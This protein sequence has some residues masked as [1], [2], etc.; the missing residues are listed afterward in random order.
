MKGKQRGGVGGG[1][2]K[3]IGCSGRKVRAKIKTFHINIINNP[4]IT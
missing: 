3:I 2:G 1:G 4:I